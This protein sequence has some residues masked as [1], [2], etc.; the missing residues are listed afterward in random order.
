MPSDSLA[1]SGSCPAVPP[2]FDCQLG[3]RASSGLCPA[4]LPPESAMLVIAWLQMV[5]RAPPLGSADLQEQL[6][7]RETVPRHRWTARQKGLGA[8]VPLGSLP[9]NPQLLLLR[10]RRVGRED[11]KLW[12]HGGIHNTRE[13]GAAYKIGV[14]QGI[15][16]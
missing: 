6:T 12:S 13:R 11:S 8:P 3:V 2:S 9:G 10:G 15:G 1:G 4:T 5:S 7:A 16:F 14:Q